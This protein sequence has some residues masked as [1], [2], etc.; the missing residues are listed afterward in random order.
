MALILNG[1]FS[2][3]LKLAEPPPFQQKM[4]C[5]ARNIATQQPL[6]NCKD[7]FTFLCFLLIAA[8]S[9]GNAWGIRSSLFIPCCWSHV[10]NRYWHVVEWRRRTD[11]W[12]E[13]SIGEC[14]DKRNFNFL[15]S[16]FLCFFFS[17]IMKPQIHK[18]IQMSAEKQSKT[19]F[20]WQ[21]TVLYKLTSEFSSIH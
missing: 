7:F 17:F 15:V 20:I 21:C 16:I 8:R 12:E 19:T 5:I 2:Y 14:L 3:S 9:Y 10:H 6:Y 4:V 11:L 1:V 13:N 18:A